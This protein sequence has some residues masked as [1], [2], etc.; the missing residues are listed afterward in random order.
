[1]YRKETRKEYSYWIFPEACS[2]L[3]QIISKNDRETLKRRIPIS[4]G[5]ATSIGA[6]LLKG[7]EVLNHGSNNSEGSEIILITD[8]EE[9]TR[10]YINEVKANIVNR[11][12]VVHT[13]AVSQTA[14]EK[15]SDLAQLTNGKSYVYLESNT[16]SFADA[17]AQT[18]LSSGP[19]STVSTPVN[20][21]SQTLNLTARQEQQMF[22][23][24]DEGLGKDTSLCFIGNK[25]ITIHV[26]VLSP[27]GDNL[28][29]NI[30]GQKYSCL[31]FPDVAKAGRYSFSIYP[32]TG[33]TV[34]ALVFSKPISLDTEVV[35]VSSWLSESSF[36]ANSNQ[37]VSV[38]T[39]VQRGRSPVFNA[40]V[41][42][43]M[44]A[45][46]DA[47]KTFSLHDNGAGMSIYI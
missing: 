1:M 13:V 17:M 28:S 12:I 20:I 14:D 6:G 37:Y 43:V 46:G 10:P 45:S 8:G 7:L 39:D 9:N 35:R 33:A 30:S 24:I 42:A 15:L 18:I 32:I 4:V 41:T 47:G 22:F 11:R 29:H 38:Y 19:F 21:F 44:Q 26:S 3:T 27:V 5:G 16:V 2:N 31:V 25:L 23:Y 40:T 36:K 34:N